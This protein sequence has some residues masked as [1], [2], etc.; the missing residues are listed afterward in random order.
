MIK[1]L[2]RVPD[3]LCVAVSGGS[4]SMASR[5]TTSSLDYYNR[6]TETYEPGTDEIIGIDVNVVVMPKKSALGGSS[7]SIPMKDMNPDF[8]S[9]QDNRTR[10]NSIDSMLSRSPSGISNA[11]GGP[12]FNNI[13]YKAI[14]KKYK[15]I[16]FAVYGFVLIGLIFLNT[17]PHSEVERYVNPGIYRMYISYMCRFVDVL[18]ILL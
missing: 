7:S 9:L 8:V 17:T 5:N 15:Q 10:M 11:G 2:G 14:P 3:T 18:G 1:L 12:G 13:V 6:D 4:D 16:H